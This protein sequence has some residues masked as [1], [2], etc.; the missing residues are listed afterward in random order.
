MSIVFF[1]VTA[2]RALLDKVVQTNRQLEAA[3]EELQSTNEEL[4]T[5]NEELQSTVEELETTNEELQSTNEELETMNEELQSTNDELHTIN[6]TL[7]ERSVELDEARTFLDSLVNSVQLGMVVVDREM[8]V[9]VWNRASE[10]LW[11]LRGDETTGE[12][13]PALDIGLPMDGGAAVDRQ[14]VRRSREFG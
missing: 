1:D 13:F 9:A 12:S 8:K 7:R 3:Y 2:T 5:T 6:D 14:R 11:G 4:E 10:D